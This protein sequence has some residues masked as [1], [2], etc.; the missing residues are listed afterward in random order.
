[1]S[2]SDIL[3]RDL[4]YC[5]CTQSS[6]YTSAGKTRITKPAIQNSGTSSVIARS[7]PPT[8]RPYFIRDE[9][10]EIIKSTN[11][12]ALFVS[13][14]KEDALMVADKVVILN[15]GEIAQVGSP[16]EVIEAPANDYV[17]NFFK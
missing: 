15:R 14:D 16:V 10:K 2:N 7:M 4:V 9:L 5:E 6:R 17:S 1:M 3:T 8:I 13:Q 11:T 12:T